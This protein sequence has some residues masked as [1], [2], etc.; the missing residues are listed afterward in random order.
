M[1]RSISQLMISAAAVVLFVATAPL[2]AQNVDR[3]NV[4]VAFHIGYTSYEAGT[5]DL[6][7]PASPAS[8]MTVSAVDGANTTFA[9][10]GPV[11]EQTDKTR[12]RGPVLILKC[13]SKGCFVTEI[14]TD[15]KGYSIRHPMSVDEQVASNTTHVLALTRVVSH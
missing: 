5:Y 1:K 6:K 9:M 13:A 15:T 3:A 4:P 11:I 14:W 8:A 7:L 10:V 12:A 2:H